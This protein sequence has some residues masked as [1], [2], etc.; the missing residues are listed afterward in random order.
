ME[1]T[2]TFNAAGQLTGS[3]DGTS[4]VWD[5]NGQLTKVDRAG[6][7][8]DTTL[9]YA[10]FG[11]VAGQD[12][13][14]SAS[15]YVRD[16]LGRVSSTTT[17][18]AGAGTRTYGYTG[19]AS[20]IS[21]IDAGANDQSIVRG[22]E[23]APLALVQS[24]GSTT[25]TQHAWLNLHGDLTGWRA[26]SG[27][28][29]TS[30]SLYDPFGTPAATGTNPSI[31]GFQAMPQDATTGLVD[32]GARSYNPSTASFTAEDTVIG[33][34]RAPIT[35][36][37]YTYANGAPLDYC[38]PDGRWSFGGF[39]S[40]VGS[41]LVSL[42]SKLVEGTKKGI[43]AVHHAASSVTNSAS[44]AVSSAVSTVT[45]AVS[46]TVGGAANALAT[47]ARSTV[48]AL[49]QGFSQ[50]GTDVK[51]SI[52]R[53][54]GKVKDLAQT[55]DAAGGHDILNVAGF[56]QGRSGRGRCRE[57]WPLLHRG[58]HQECADLPCRHDCPGG[59]VC[60]DRW[61]GSQG[62]RTTRDHRSQ[63]ARG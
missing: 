1:V 12:Q 18:G 45:S 46:S 44:S 24:N 9:G 14:A 22:A 49:Q 20:Q 13:G 56:I 10:A 57:R 29:W 17:T 62:R 50:I 5:D 11:E 42:G 3:S 52:A 37:R 34:L 28:A 54:R 19:L 60:R 43:K 30:T 25:T 35:L 51:Q 38:D 4:Y 15:T 26:Q 40:S 58:R 61:C 16:A 41:G 48:K 53:G 55:L 27:G 33:D 39:V 32:M 21:E 36:N 7:A 47:K 59:W 2:S 23:G 63:E 8:D 31:L 6:G